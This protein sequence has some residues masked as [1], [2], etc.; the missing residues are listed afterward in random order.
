MA[1]QSGLGD[2][3]YV[4][5]FDL[6]GDVNSVD[7]ISGGPN[8]LDFTTI[9]KS[10]NVRQGALR[11]GE[12]D[13]TTFLDPTV[14]H[15]ALKGLPTADVIMTYAR[16]T[17]LG[18]DAACCNAKQVGYDPTRATDGSILLKVTGQSN[19]FGLEWGK[20][21]TAGLRTDSAAT[22]GAAW[23]DGAPSS[24][25]GQAYF[26][27]VAFTGTSVTIDIQHATTSGGTYA[28]TGL[29]SQA[30]TGIGAQRVAI[31]NNVTID[32]FLK[33]VTTGTFSNA[34][35]SVVFMRNPVAVVF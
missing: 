1:K 32:E 30:F 24:F 14:A 13:F 23:D 27:L 29:T 20:Q 17:A 15:L 4:A 16:G 8:P 34:V 2:N 7:Q 35:F 19:S 33:V 3:F 11:S 22:I 28:S 25:G 5:G 18:G 10:A 21:L 12:M 6:S 31:A 26:Q 9:N